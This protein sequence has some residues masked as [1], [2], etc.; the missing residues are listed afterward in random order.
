MNALGLYTCSTAAAELS[1]TPTRVRALIAAKRLRATLVGGV[2]LIEP[3][4][5]D[6]VRSRKSGRPPSKRNAAVG[7]PP[8]PSEVVVVLQ[9]PVEQT[10][11]RVWNW[12]N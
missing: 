11:R 4:D 7:V 3:A 6:A 2:W 1:V 8:K 12:M 9:G 10:A 5:L